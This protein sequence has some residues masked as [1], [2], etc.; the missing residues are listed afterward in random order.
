MAD[1]RR[2][3]AHRLNPKQIS[4]AV[5][6]AVA[7][8]A[9]VVY[10][11]S[12]GNGFAYDDEMIVQYR[13]I[14]H[15]F[16]S[17]RD[18]LS[19]EYWPSHLEAGLYR[20]LTLLSFAVEWAVWGGNPFG[21][22]LTN[23]VLHALVSVLVAIFLLRFFPW[24]AALAG[25]LVFA[26][27]PVHTE[28]IANVIGRAEL[29]TA[30]FALAACLIYDSAAR[31][32]RIALRPI[33]AIS[34]LFLLAC[35]SKEIAV[36]IPV[37][38]LVTDLPRLSSARGDLRQF[39]RSRLPLFANLSG[40]LLLVLGIRLAVLGAAVEG[41]PNRIFALDGSFAT[42]LFTMLRVWPTY[43]ELLLFPLNLSADYS[44]AVILPVDGLTLTGAVG[45]AMVFATLGLAALTF[46]RV[47]ELMMAAAWAIIA[48]LPVSNLLFT[49][50]FTLAERTLYLPSVAV[51]ILVATALART[52]P[53]GRR[54]IALGIG[55]W[56]LAFSVV[57]V[58][59]NPVWYSTETVFDDIRRQHPES[60][61][62]LWILGHRFR[63]DGYW[64]EAKRW[65]ERSLE[66]WPHHAPYQADYAAML[67][68]RGELEAADRR[69]TLAIEL[70]PDYRHFHRLRALIRMH[71]GDF[72]AALDAVDEGLSAVGPDAVLYML[73]ADA[74]AALDE[75]DR[76]VLAQQ[77]V[78]RE[79]GMTDWEAW[80]RLA[81]LRAVAGD[82][83]AALATLDSAV[84]AQGEAATLDSM[85]R[86]WTDSN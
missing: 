65:F 48:I 52:K 44:P 51:A 42:R 12:L 30:V 76:A 35:L 41:V 60:S 4:T 63:R 69:A 59:R 74:F 66:I 17:A 11:N 24:W 32:G 61:R 56:L 37:L 43:F 49:T 8:A 16:G 64:E 58:R 79:R 46:K 9:A 86:I 84:V 47:P 5:V 18:L 14:I 6:I 29:L 50:A 28:V 45:F 85:R 73:Q 13:D 33:V 26:I 55:L 15:H 7:L 20:P 38:L 83:A 82:T 3:L 81:Q 71:A 77:K 72:E 75:P 67:R 10:A 1:Y 25:G 19:A 62:M 23:V 31:S 22:H 70:Q 2:L 80:M 39:A 68:E 21:F 40:V 53:P 27:H 36:V 57:T 34:A 78:V 54:I